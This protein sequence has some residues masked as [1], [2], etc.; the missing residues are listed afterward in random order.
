MGTPSCIEKTVCSSEHPGFHLGLS[1]FTAT[2]TPLSAIGQYWLAKYWL[3]TKEA[4]SRLHDIQ[5]HFQRAGRVTGNPSAWA[6]GPQASH[7]ESA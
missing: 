6:S 5:S 1:R 2:I 7:W 4:K 3:A